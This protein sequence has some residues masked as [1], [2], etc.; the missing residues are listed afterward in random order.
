VTSVGKCLRLGTLQ[1]YGT[2]HNCS[3]KLNQL[4][5]RGWSLAQLAIATSI[6]YLTYHIL[7]SEGTSEYTQR[8]TLQSMFWIILDL[9]RRVM[10]KNME[11][12]ERHKGKGK[13][14]G[15]GN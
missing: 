10:G 11:K 7:L 4:P 1:M 3:S 6:A 14:K 15:I 12:E 9:F 2:V 5:I 13:G 8:R